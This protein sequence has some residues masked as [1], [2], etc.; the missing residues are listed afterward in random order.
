MPSRPIH[1]N[2]RRLAEWC[3]KDQYCVRVS[4]K[5]IADWLV[6]VSCLLFFLGGGG[7]I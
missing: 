2:E 4:S 6:F 7:A 5:A 3:V 1:R